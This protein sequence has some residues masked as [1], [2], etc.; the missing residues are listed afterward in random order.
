MKIVS[1]SQAVTTTV[2]HNPR[3]G[4]KLLLGNGELGPITN[5]AQAV[6]PPGEV[7]GEHAHTDMG[8][9]F[10]INSGTGTIIIDGTEYPIAPGDCVVVEANERHEIRNTGSEE[11]VVTY[12][13]V[14]L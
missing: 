7:A 1:L 4:K 14:R 2:S 10:M 6:F 12:F 13:G 5:L 11:L 3:I 8:E 9:V